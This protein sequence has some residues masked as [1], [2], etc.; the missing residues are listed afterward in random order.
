MGSVPCFVL[1]HGLL[2]E[3]WVSWPGSHRRILARWGHLATCRSALRWL[4][5]IL[6]LTL[7]FM[8]GGED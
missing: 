2:A 8:A 1:V 4:M 5:L 7:S 3:G 6:I